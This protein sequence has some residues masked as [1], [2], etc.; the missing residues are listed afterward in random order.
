M[1]PSIS[2]LLTA[3]KWFNFD[4]WKGKDP[5]FC[6]HPGTSRG[7]APSLG[8]TLPTRL[9]RLELRAPCATKTSAS[10]LHG[11]TW[12]TTANPQDTTRYFR[13][14]TSAGKY[15]VTNTKGVASSRWFPSAHSRW[16]ST[17]SN[18]VTSSHSWVS[19]VA[20]IKRQVPHKN[21][22]GAGNE[23]GG[24]QS[25]SQVWETVQAHLLATVIYFRIKQF[26]SIYE[27]Y[28]F[29]WLRSSEDINT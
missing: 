26:P 8:N 19:R 10:R 23:G 27:Y 12:D 3:P 21:Q 6:P 25:D 24:L 1:C 4:S 13:V 14:G 16:R 5:S 22:H 2:P 18:D 29:K 17:L 20:P 11:D 28:F 9:Q 15:D 7:R